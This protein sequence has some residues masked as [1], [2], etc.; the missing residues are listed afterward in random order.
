MDSVNK[1]LYI[2][3][4]GK[5]YVSRQGILIHDPKVADALAMFCKFMDIEAVRGA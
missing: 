1:T 4:Y 3:L 2:P 5:A